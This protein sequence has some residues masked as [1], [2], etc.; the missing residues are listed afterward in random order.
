MAKRK[1]PAEKPDRDAARE[2][3]LA[4]FRGIVLGSSAS[5]RPTSIW[6]AV[7]DVEAARTLQDRGVEDGRTFRDLKEHALSDFDAAMEQWPS[8]EV[9]VMHDYADDVARDSARAVNAPEDGAFDEW[10]ED[11]EGDA[12]GIF[13]SECFPGHPACEDATKF[14]ALV[15][16]AYSAGGVPCAVRGFPGGPIAIFV[17][18]AR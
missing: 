12:K 18:Q 8:A 14:F 3:T 2:R 4:F 16:E 11:L 15:R 7:R 10:L 17:G 6:K 1:T 13:L 9:T 5:L